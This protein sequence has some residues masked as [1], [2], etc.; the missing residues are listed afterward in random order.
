MMDIEA[1]VRDIKLHVIEI[2]EKKDELMYEKE[3]TAMMKLAEKS[4]S[5]FFEDEPDIYKYLQ[6]S[7]LNF[8]R[9]MF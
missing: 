2:S 7:H 6:K 5:G 8:L 9:L 3:I 1:E 4:L